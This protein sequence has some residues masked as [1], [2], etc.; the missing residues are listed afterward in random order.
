MLFIFPL[1]LSGSR[2]KKQQLLNYPSGIVS[3]IDNNLKFLLDSIQGVCFSND[4]LVA[5]INAKKVYGNL[6]QTVFSIKLL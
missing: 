4:N 1:P 5:S 6:G 3:D 2:A